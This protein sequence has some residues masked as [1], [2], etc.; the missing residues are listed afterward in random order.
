MKLLPNVFPIKTS[1]TKQSIKVMRH[2][3][4]FIADSLKENES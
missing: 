4:Y 2:M 1:S 3:W